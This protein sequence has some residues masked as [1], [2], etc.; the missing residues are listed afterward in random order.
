MAQKYEKKRP[1]SMAARALKV[2]L[3]FFAA[4]FIG[5]WCATYN[6]FARLI[7]SIQSTFHE[8]SFQ[9]SKSQSKRP[10]EQAALPKPKFE[11]YTL[12]AHEQAASPD[13]ILPPA[14]KTLE[15]PATQAVQTKSVGN[16]VEPSLNAPRQADVRYMLQVASFRKQADADRMKA[17]LILNGFDARVVMISREGAHWYRVVLGPFASRM[18]A[19]TI[20]V[21]VARSEHLMGMILKVT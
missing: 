14:S 8:N 4:F 12:L 3:L 16:A 13:R 2:I 5:Y 18:Q 19:E 9:Q 1:K 6:G 7:S 21:E 10:V 20:Q 17:D 11:F 15:Q